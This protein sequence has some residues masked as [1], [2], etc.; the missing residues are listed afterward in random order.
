MWIRFSVAFIFLFFYLWRRGGTFKQILKLPPLITLCCVLG[1]GI[2]YVAYLEGLA[3]TGPSNA[4]IIIQAGPLLLAIAGVILFREK[5]NQRQY[6]SLLVL[7]VGFYFFYSDR[8]SNL[9]EEKTA[10]H[11]GSLWILLGAFFWA[12]YGIFQKMIVRDHHP[13][14]LN[15]VIYGV[16]SVIY[17][18][19]IHW[20]QF[21]VLNGWQ[22]FLVLLLGLN[23][24]LAYGFLGEALKHTPANQ[25]GVIITIN[26]MITILLM[27]IFEWINVKWIIQEHIHLRGYVGALIFMFGAACFILFSNKKVPI[28]RV[29]SI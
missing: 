23:T 12:L 11:H 4:Q 6:L 18:P 25:V 21:H 26:P 20:Q 1:L 29:N 14:I 22:W 3:I 19:L 9:L 16:C 24:L 27:G 13:Q 17:A 7:A 28:E 8:L 15:L 5:I 2:N 10:F